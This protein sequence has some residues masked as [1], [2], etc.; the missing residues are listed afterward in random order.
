[1]W[2]F[3]RF[4]RYDVDWLAIFVIIVILF[5]GGMTLKTC[6]ELFD[7]PIKCECPR[8]KNVPHYISY[9]ADN[10]SNLRTSNRIRR[11]RHR[12][13]AMYEGSK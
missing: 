4:L 7:R 12:R 9:N 6:D 3:L 13:Q 1:M 10:S 8:R 11:P 2:R 5:A